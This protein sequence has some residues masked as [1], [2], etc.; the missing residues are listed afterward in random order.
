MRHCY[1]NFS[2]LEYLPTFGVERY[3]FCRYPPTSAVYQPICLGGHF[4]P[5]HTLP[6]AC[7][8][9][10]RLL[11]SVRQVGVA[12]HSVSHI[13]LDTCPTFIQAPDPNQD[14]HSKSRKGCMLHV[15]ARVRLFFGLVQLVSSAIWPLRVCP[16]SFPCVGAA[17]TWAWPGQ[18]S[19]GWSESL[20]STLWIP[21]SILDGAWVC[22]WSNPC[23]SNLGIPVLNTGGD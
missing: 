18:G 20:W 7:P 23:W 14:Q 15:L 8:R 17:P 2:S 5:P 13:S 10:Y 9:K 11:F 19:S 21:A 3:S 6:I 22:D 1:N 4:Q 12:C 16:L